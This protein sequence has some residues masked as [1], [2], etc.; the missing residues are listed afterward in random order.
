MLAPWSGHLP[1]EL[2]KLLNNK[3]SFLTPVT[4]YLP[5]DQDYKITISINSI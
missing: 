2:L 1:K 3:E 5:Q 4:D